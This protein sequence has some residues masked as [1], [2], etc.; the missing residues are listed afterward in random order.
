MI[1]IEKAILHILDFHSGVTVYSDTELPVKDSIETWLLKH[2]EKAWGSQDAKP[3]SFYDDSAFLRQIGSYAAGELG[4][5]DFSKQIA[6]TLEDAFTHAEEMPSSD[7][8]VAAVSIDESRI[9][10]SCAATATSVSRI[11]STRRRTASR[12]RSSTTIPSCRTS[13]RRSTN[14]PL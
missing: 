10:S 3:G 6:K 8:I 13:H 14:S 1:I 7:V 4:F 5:I 12:T 2:I 9:S 11:R